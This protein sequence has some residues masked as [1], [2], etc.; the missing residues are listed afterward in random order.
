MAKKVLILSG[1]PRKG[2]NS[3]MLALAFAKGVVDGGNEVAI[4]EAGR[5]KIGGCSVCETCWSKGQACS[6]KDDFAGLEPYLEICD[7]IAFVSPVYWYS[8]T[9]QIKAAID[10]FVAYAVPFRKK[11]MSIKGGYLLM[12]AGDTDMEVFDGSV[13]TYKGILGFQKWENLG[14]LLAPGI[15]EKG[16]IE[17]SGFLAEAYELGK[18]VK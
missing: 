9:T 7:I 1:S 12:C 6:V 17:N 4:F 5:K 11:E 8:F 14:M 18:G 15:Y 10:K 2:G 13:A 3:N 16:D